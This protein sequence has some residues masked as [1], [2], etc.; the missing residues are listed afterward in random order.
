VK[1]V[2]LIACSNGY[3]HLRRL[4]LL[5]RALHKISVKSVL[6][7]PLASVER[8][9]TTESVSLPEIVDFDSGTTISNWLNG[10]ATNWYQYLPDLKEYDIVVSDNLIEILLVRPDA[11]LSGSFF[12]HESLE[13]FP[14]DLKNQTEELLRQHQPRMLSSRM[15]A[16][17]KLRDNTNLYKV[18][19]FSNRKKKPIYHKNKC[20][21]LISCGRGRV[22]EKETKS[23]L[24]ILSQESSIPFGT[25]WVEPSIIP[26]KPPNWMKEATF[27]SQMYENVIAAVI[28]P[29]IGTVTNALAAGARIFS[30]YEP[31]NKEMRENG[32][33]IEKYNYGINSS[34]IE[35]AWNKAVKYAYDEQAKMQHFKELKSID[36]EGAEEAARILYKYIQNLEDVL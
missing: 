4:L 36:L 1:K 6:F 23:F 17:E 20:D 22:L 14:E 25:V 30:F 3:G 27:N 7:A 26:D 8:L 33:R 21:F 32:I 9:A 24:N 12:W 16:S 28:R 19:L 13:Q 29:G 31:G 11:W 2:A 5:S 34:S 10:S 18:G 15:F 35:I